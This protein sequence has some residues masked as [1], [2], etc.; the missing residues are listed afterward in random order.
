MQTSA[1]RA[2][3]RG[4]VAMTRTRLRVFPAIPRNPNATQHIDDLMRVAR[5]AERYA[6][7]AVGNGSAHYRP[8]REDLAADCR[9]PA[10]YASVH[11]RQVRLVIRA[12]PP[13]EDLSQYD[14]RDGDE[15][16]GGA[17]R[18]ARS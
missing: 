18:A 5:F 12:A 2:G 16:S 10:L 9:Q 15:R 6:G 11:G 17:G 7:R 4:S 3:G 1:S 14:Q 13:P 8:H